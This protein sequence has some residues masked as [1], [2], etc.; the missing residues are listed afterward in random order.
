MKI[1][2]ELLKSE[3]INLK[4]SVQ[5]VASSLKLSSRVI[6]FIEAGDLDSLPSKTFVRGF[7]KS[8]A[9]IL[10][11]DTDAVLRQFQEEMGSTSPLPKIP[12]PLPETNDNNIKSPRPALKHTAQN[13]SVKNSTLKNPVFK[14]ND[15]KKNIFFMII[16]AGLLISILITSNKIISNFKNDP[17]AIEP[18]VASTVPEAAPLAAKPTTSTETQ[19]PPL[20]TTASADSTQTNVNTN[21]ISA[22]NGYLASSGKPV[23]ILIEAKK[24]TEVFYARGDSKQLTA[25][26]MTANQIQVLKS[27][28]GLYLKLPD[29]SAIKLHVNG[30]NKVLTNGSN[31]ETKLSF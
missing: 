3:R 22:E 11:L 4:L 1:T 25:L 15:H 5:D 6:N 14:D 19:P 26:E 9:Q 23:E 18:V 29:S 24:E 8:Y 13:Y 12:P 30:V 21:N 31:K 28:I 27:E 16:I 2:G 10:K 17:V 7:V 20:T